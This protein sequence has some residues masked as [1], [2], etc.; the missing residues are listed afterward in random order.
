MKVGV[1]QLLNTI[2]HL[3]NERSRAPLG[4]WIRPLSVSSKVLFI[5]SSNLAK[6]WH[7]RIFARLLK[8]FPLKIWLLFGRCQ[9]FARFLKPFRIEFWLLFGHC[10]I[11]ARFL[12]PFY[13]K[14]RHP[15]EHSPIFARFLNFLE[16]LTGSFLRLRHS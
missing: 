14:I 9:I 7:C 16:L 8:P 15:F 4:E 2:Q 3:K 13:I 12:M 5:C 6:I 11:F 10:P 1:T